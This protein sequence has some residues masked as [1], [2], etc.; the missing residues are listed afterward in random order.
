MS[1]DPTRKERYRIPKNLKHLR[2]NIPVNAQRWA[3][4]DHVSRDIPSASQT[5]G[6]PRLEID[7]NPEDVSEGRFSPPN[8][9]YDNTLQ[10]NKPEVFSLQGPI[11]SQ[12]TSVPSVEGQNSDAVAAPSYDASL[13]LDPHQQLHYPQVAPRLHSATPPSWKIPCSP[14]VEVNWHSHF[15]QSE[16]VD[17]TP[18]AF[19][20]PNTLST[21]TGGYSENPPYGRW[22]ERHLG[23]SIGT[24]HTPHIPT[25]TP[26]EL[27]IPP[28]LRVI[29]GV[30]VLD[31]TYR[32]SVGPGAPGAG[33]FIPDEDVAPVQNWH[34]DMRPYA[35]RRR[36]SNAHA[37]PSSTFA[38]HHHNFWPD[39]APYQNQQ[40]PM[41]N[42]AYLHAEPASLDSGPMG[43]FAAHPDQTTGRIGLAHSSPRA[44]SSSFNRTVT[45]QE[46]AFAQSH[47]DSG[48]LPL[49]GYSHPSAQIPTATIPTQSERHAASAG[50][51]KRKHRAS[52]DVPADVPVAGSSRNPIWSQHLGCFPSK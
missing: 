30:F 51:R 7:A 34:A 2:H 11:A 33:Y 39:D 49:P 20:L 8:P 31:P 15:Q 3:L 25:N 40:P 1:D 14:S 48:A 35:G 12:T 42:R 28:R 19:Y 52:P 43:S 38:A 10:E 21:P 6:M 5:Q 22:E 47:Q 13:P 16:S 26:A 24:R 45:S 32:G 46:A 27:G 17:N 23:S 36:F 44:V 37:P 29:R 18:G 9:F 41:H 4:P 50:G